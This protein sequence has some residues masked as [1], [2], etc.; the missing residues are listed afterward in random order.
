MD[1]VQT[2]ELRFC[3]WIRIYS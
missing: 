2:K 3:V 1:M